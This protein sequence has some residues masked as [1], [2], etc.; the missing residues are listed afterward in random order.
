M[1]QIAVTPLIMSHTQL[2]RIKVERAYQTLPEGAVT[3]LRLE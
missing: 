3:L 2:E 1:K